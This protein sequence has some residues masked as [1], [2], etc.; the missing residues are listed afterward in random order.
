MVLFSPITPEFKVNSSN[1]FVDTITN[2]DVA[3]ASDDNFIIVWEEPFQ[4]D[5]NDKD[6][7]FRRFAPDGTPL[8]VN[9]R[10]EL[11]RNLTKHNRLLL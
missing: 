7:K 9:D 5:N 8:D 3:V 4:G 10:I 1:I 6:I 2:P 11:M